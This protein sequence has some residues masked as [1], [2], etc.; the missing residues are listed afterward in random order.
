MNECMYTYIFFCICV[1]MCMFICILVH[2]LKYR[3]QLTIYQWINDINR[4]K[5][6]GRIN[7][8]FH[9]SSTEFTYS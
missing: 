7:F 1:Y 5:L 2:S 9:V 6:L 3:V 4:I 8:N